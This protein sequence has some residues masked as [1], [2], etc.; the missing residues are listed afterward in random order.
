MN[1]RTRSVVSKA[2]WR[3][4]GHRVTLICTALTASTGVML[5]SGTMLILASCGWAASFAINL[6]RSQSWKDAVRGLDVTSIELPHEI[7]VKEA[8][9]R[10]FLARLTSTRMERAAL[11]PGSSGR[12]DPAGRGVTARAVE[13]ERAAVTLI[14]SLDRMSEHLAA[15]TAASLRAELVRLQQLGAGSDVAAARLEAE[16]ATAIVRGRLM[17]I[18]DI[19]SCKALVNARLEAIVATLEALPCRLAR[20]EAARSSLRTLQDDAPLAGLN[21]EL[22]NLDVAARV[23]FEKQVEHPVDDEETSPGALVLPAASA[24]S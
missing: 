20:A 2:L 13:L 22:E 11:L 3:A 8:V 17:A 12:R 5:Q 15:H 24:A 19:E 6:T 10:Q 1:E 21:E 9:A 16:R 14:Q 18:E 23:T 4:A 7:N